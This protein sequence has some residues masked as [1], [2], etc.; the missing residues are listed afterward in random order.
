[1]PMVRCSDCGLLGVRKNDTNQLVECMEDMR[2]GR[3]SSQI[4]MPVCAA[5][6]VSFWTEAEK[7]LDNVP[8]EL[9]RQ[10]EC[11]RFVKWECGF[12]PKEHLEMVRGFAH[13]G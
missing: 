9:S 2:E 10:R 4:S 7:Q 11:D 5:C 3:K 12:T 13:K 6:V 8:R 1:M